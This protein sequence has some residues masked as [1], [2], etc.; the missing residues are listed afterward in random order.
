MHKG[1]FLD[2]LRRKPALF[3]AMLAFNGAGGAASGT[4]GH[5][6]ALQ[7]L[8][9]AVPGAGEGLLRSPR[10]RRWLNGDG[11]AAVEQFW[12]FAEES[13]RL[14]LLDAAEVDR[15]AHVFGVAL[16]APDFARLVLRDDVLALRTE[17][18][19]ELYRYGLQRGRYQLGGVRRHFAPLREAERT[20][21]GMAE[22]VRADG[23]RALALCAG[24]WPEPLK[25]RLAWPAHLAPQGDEARPVT[26]ETDGMPPE[27]GED[28]R[29]QDAWRGVWFGLKK[30]LLKEVAPRWAPCF[31]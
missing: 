21:A 20:G 28:P 5:D 17:L 18:G 25:A 19:E 12:D 13:R 29:R 27:G 1:F 15:L 11:A 14:A 7:A 8:R 24:R 4:P 6:G 23:A 26:E 9:H 2:V 31:D 22:R 3:A 10:L 16:H 30:L